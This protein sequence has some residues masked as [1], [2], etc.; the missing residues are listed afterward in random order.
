MKIHASSFVALLAAGLV[1]G[2]AAAACGGDDSSD[3]QP[4]R[5]TDPK[6]VPTA[7][8]WAQGD[9]PEVIPIDPDSI[10]PISAEA[11]PPPSTGSGETSSGEPGVCG[12]TYTIKSDDTLFDIA[13]KCEVSLDDLKAAN[14]GLDP[15]TLRIGQTIEL[16]PKDE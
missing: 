2:I 5:L 16:P 14:P 9:A 12:E 11:T 3:F 10:K 7:T 6:D 8:P 15:A 13:R 1:L 4:G